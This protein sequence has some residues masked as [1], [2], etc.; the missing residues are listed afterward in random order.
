MATKKR[1]FADGDVVEGQN[2]GIG[3]DTRARAMRWLQ[4][5][6]EGGGAEAAPAETA[7][8]VVRQRPRARPATP[9]TDTGDELGRLAAR[10]KPSYEPRYDSMN[11]KN[12][13]NAAAAKAA[14]DSE[15]AVLRENIRSKRS[16]AVNPKTLLPVGMKKG[17]SVASR[18][19]D[20]IAQRGK[21]KG[22]MI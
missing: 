17:G 22:R 2:V 11:R 1:K 15:R 21:T 20:G 6:Q 12:R 13:E 18:R 19:A 9:V 3:D 7:Q 4:Q 10:T 16:G 14:A 8:P 5:Q